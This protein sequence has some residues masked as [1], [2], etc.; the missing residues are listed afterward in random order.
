MIKETSSKVSK[1]KGSKIILI[2]MKKGTKK[3]E[4]IG[5]TEEI[6]TIGT[7]GTIGTSRII[8]DLI[9]TPMTSTTIS[10][11]GRTTDSEV[12]EVQEEGGIE[13]VTETITGTTILTTISEMNMSREEETST[14]LPILAIDKKIISILKIV[15]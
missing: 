4:E 1:E 9:E 13:V 3:T 8:I 15:K 2:I 12:I 10:I 11:A 6:G 14:T 7:T 5:M